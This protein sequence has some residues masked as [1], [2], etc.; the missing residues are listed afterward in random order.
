MTDKTQHELTEDDKQAIAWV[1]AQLVKRGVPEVKLGSWA[2]LTVEEINAHIRADFGF[3]HLATF[4][5]RQGLNVD[6]VATYH[7][8]EVVTVPGKV[9][10]DPAT[11]QA[12][13]E[14]RI[15]RNKRA[16][17]DLE[18]ALRT[19]GYAPY[20]EQEDAAMVRRNP[21]V[22]C[23]GGCA[24]KGYKTNFTYRAF[25]VCRDCFH[26]EEL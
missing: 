19:E 15:N 5:V 3:K 9:L 21:C 2:E 24:Y 14:R 10:P 17:S 1:T 8:V 16:W 7:L 20:I 26:Y 18:H 6:D 22:K 25:A 23:G 11:I 12:E 13:E 4:Q